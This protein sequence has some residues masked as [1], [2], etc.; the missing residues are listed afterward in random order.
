MFITFNC[1]GQ[2]NNIITILRIDSTVNSIDE[3]KELR[4]SILIKNATTSN[5]S[6]DSDIVIGY[7]EDSDVQIYFDIRKFNNQ[8]EEDTLKIDH[9]D[10]DNFS[11]SMFFPKQKRVLVRGQ[12]FEFDFNLKERYPIK[13][14][15]VY[16]L[17]CYYDILHEKKFQKSNTI[18][19]ILK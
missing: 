12:L 6:F 18:L 15:G 1:K 16:S 11:M 7:K 9:V 14:K 13:S 4:V 5:I 19:F 10:Y 3:D 8:L 2:K 17:T